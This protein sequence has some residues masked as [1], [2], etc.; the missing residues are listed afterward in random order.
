[1]FKSSIQNQTETIKKH[2]QKNYDFSNGIKD[3]LIETSAKRSEFY[4]FLI[5]SISISRRDNF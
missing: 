2:R 3:N 1:M 5:G 4:R